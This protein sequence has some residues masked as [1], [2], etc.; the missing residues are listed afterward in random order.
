M[1]TVQQSIADA[2]VLGISVPDWKPD[3]P[4][5]KLDE[6]ADALEGVAKELRL[7]ANWRTE[8]NEIV[9]VFFSRRSLHLRLAPGSKIE[10]AVINGTSKFDASGVADEQG[11]VVVDFPV[12]RRQKDATIRIVVTHGHIPKG[13]LSRDYT[14]QRI[15]GYDKYLEA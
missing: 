14:M 11:W 6:I 2:K 8:G 12:F 7:H 4:V 3:L 1:N 5:A 10:L 13:N 15:W 9:S